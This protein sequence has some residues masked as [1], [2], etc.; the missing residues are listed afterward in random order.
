LYRDIDNKIIGGV[1]SG[2]GH[3]FNADPVII[4][5]MFVILTFFAAGGILI[6]FVLWIILPPA[7]N[8]A[9][10]MHMKGY[11]VNIPNS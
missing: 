8:V 9:E 2:M 4:R 3:Y 7:F 11:R 6:Y 10:K 1:C 5:I